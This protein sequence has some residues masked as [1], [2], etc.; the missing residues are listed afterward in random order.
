MPTPGGTGW[1]G[2]RLG[3]VKVTVRCARRPR[4]VLIPLSAATGIHHGLCQLLAVNRKLEFTSGEIRAVVGPM[5]KPV[6]GKLMTALSWRYRSV[7]R[8]QKAVRIWA[9]PTK[10]GLPM[11][12]NF[13]ELNAAMALA[14][15]DRL[16]TKNL[17]LIGLWMDVAAEGLRASKSGKDLNRTGELLLVAASWLTDEKKRLLDEEKLRQVRLN[18]AARSAGLEARL[19]R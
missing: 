16:K 5:S 11:S 7:R 14:E 1:G 19:T 8:N 9:A 17:T 18:S 2:L 4:R 3:S 15:A 13:P 12:S 10:E 6:F